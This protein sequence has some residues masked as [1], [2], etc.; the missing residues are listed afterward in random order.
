MIAVGGFEHAGLGLAGDNPGGSPAVGLLSTHFTVAGRDHC[1]RGP[2][3]RGRALAAAVAARLSP[4]SLL[5][6]HAAR[7]PRH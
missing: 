1:T 7:H 5:Q 4:S 6:P 3:R 2:V